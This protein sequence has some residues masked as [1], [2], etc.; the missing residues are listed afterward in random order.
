MRN[1]D[2]FRVVVESVSSDGKGIARM[3]N[4]KVLFVAGG[5]PEE[6]LEVVLLRESRD[7]AVAGIENIITKNR[8][9]FTPICLWYEMCGGCQ[10]QHATYELQLEIKKRIVQDA[11]RRIAKLEPALGIDE[12]VPSPRAWN[13]RN[14]ASFPVR[15]GVSGMRT[16]FFK[17]GT[18][19]LAPIDAC[20]VMEKKI[21]T[22][23]RQILVILPE[24]PLSPYDERNHSGLLRHIV[25]RSGSFT[26][27]SLVGLVCREFPTID[28]VDRIRD[29][30]QATGKNA[31]RGLCINR[32][33]EKSN[34]ILGSDVSRISGEITV[35]ERLDPYLFRYGLT[36]FFQINSF[37]AKRLYAYVAEQ[38]GS[39][40]NLLELYAGIGTLTMYLA[41][42]Y[43]RITAVEEWATAGKTIAETSSVNR[44]AHITSI[45]GSAEK[46][47]REL[48]DRYE[49]VVVDPPRTGCDRSVLEAIGDIVTP[50]RIV[51][52]SC[53]PATL[54][55]DVRILHEK[56]FVL[57]RLRPFDM[58][59]QT[60]H[61]ECVATLVSDRVSKLSR[62]D[63][64]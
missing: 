43:R 57:E 53:N 55:R 62:P 28:A 34:V 14:K 30:F 45:V 58:F 60:T 36:D 54:S 1:R 48:P 59:P 11:F 39:G 12:C 16:G 51:Y 17:E 22:L 10:L 6:E 13:Y 56:G 49:T 3:Q 4:G 46:V 44:F 47:I 31:P 23:F 61:V 2:S 25:L 32:N 52:V 24:M 37:Q 9:R 19:D 21:E 40:E 27:D 15:G 33:R 42:A 26:G 35:R 20:P 8:R 63:R 5:L 29:L 50:Q 38:A 64:T 18:H 7:Y 41:P